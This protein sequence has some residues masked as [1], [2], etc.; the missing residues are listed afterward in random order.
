MNNITV[1]D[2][3]RDVREDEPVSASQWN[4]ILQSLRQQTQL[5][6]EPMRPDLETFWAY[7]ISLNAT[8]Q[9][10]VV[11]KT[12]FVD[13][14]WML[15]GFEIIGIPPPGYTVDD[16][17]GFIVQNLEDLTDERSVLFLDGRLVPPSSGG[18]TVT[19]FSVGKV[20]AVNRIVQQAILAPP[21]NNI[22][23]SND[24]KWGDNANFN[25][26]ASVCCWT[27]GHSVV[28]VGWAGIA[29][30]TGIWGRWLLPHIN[31]I[32]DDAFSQFCTP[33]GSAFSPNVSFDCPVLDDTPVCETTA[34]YTLENAHCEDVFSYQ[35][36]VATG[37]ETVIKLP[38]KCSEITLDEDDN[39]VCP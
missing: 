11:R 10:V 14:E 39:P 15:Y 7:V 22:D 5:V 29:F 8:R 9:E 25:M 27:M 20:I 13:D 26:A 6:S 34:C 3:L 31:F 38:C 12:Q 1:I 33:E 18:G 36:C 37:V 28:D 35:P 24:I 19:K 23:P 17:T 16:Y 2:Q 21:K 4:L 30:D 32:S